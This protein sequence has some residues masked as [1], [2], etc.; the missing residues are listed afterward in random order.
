MP[1]YE[2]RYRR[3]TAGPPYYVLALSAFK[4]PL[5]GEQLTSWRRRRSTAP[6]LEHTL[7]QGLS[8]NGRVERGSG[9][10]PATASAKV[11]GSL[12]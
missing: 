12:S 2:I 8:F 5:N 10:Q 4:D 1:S 11:S 9:A 3:R 6:S 7:W